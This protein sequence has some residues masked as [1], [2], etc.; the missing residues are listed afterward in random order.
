MTA[1]TRH[2]GV[3]DTAFLDVEDA[4]PHVS[5]AIGSV[6]VLDGP[7]PD[8]DEFTARVGPRLL[9]L[10]GATAT[11]RRGP[12][13]AAE[14]IQS[15]RFSLDHHVRRVAVTAPGDDAALD[16]LVASI[17]E[18]CLDR[19]HPLLVVRPTPRSPLR[20]ARRVVRGAAE[21]IGAAVPVAT[22]S[23]IGPIGS[24]RRY[25]VVRASLPEVA[26]AGRAFGA[27][28]TTPAPAAA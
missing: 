13:G 25:R 28:E 4:D 16:D 10:P 14:L 3:L 21:L 12:L 7:P 23:L 26:A 1:T 6:L 2:L 9:S 24:R 20:A 15:R 22:S 5:L 19:E 17:M 27:P 11:V 8:R 18:Q